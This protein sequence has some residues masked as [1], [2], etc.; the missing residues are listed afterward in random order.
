MVAV[1]R[2]VC[3]SACGVVAD[4]G[5]IT[6]ELAALKMTMG[7]LTERRDGVGD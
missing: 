3:P 6:R 5:G 2:E 1:W 7:P 4:V